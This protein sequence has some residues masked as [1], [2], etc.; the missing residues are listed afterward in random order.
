MPELADVIDAAADHIEKV[1]LTKGRYFEDH[2][3]ADSRLKSR[4]CTMGAIQIVTGYAQSPGDVSWDVVSSIGEGLAEL[5]S[6]DCI[7]DWNDKPSQR[8]GRVVAAL[9]KAA[10]KA[11]ERVAA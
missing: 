6:V 9:R 3:S 7:P 5:L 2:G 11:R 4:C 10:A 8:K 1:G